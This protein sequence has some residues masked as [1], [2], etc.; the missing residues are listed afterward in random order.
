ML[1]EARQQDSHEDYLKRAHAQFK[2]LRRGEE[3]PDFT[4]RS[5]GEV[6][7]SRPAVEAAITGKSVAKN[8][9]LNPS[10]SARASSAAPQARSSNSKSQWARSNNNESGARLDDLELQQLS[11][12]DEDGTDSDIVDFHANHNKQ[13]I[14]LTLAQ[15]QASIQYYK[16]SKMNYKNYLER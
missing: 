1:Y 14:N 15:Q 9:N 11:E 7:F 16:V 2:K 8:L 5:I 10:S 4:N 3:S 12:D 13:Q 6:D